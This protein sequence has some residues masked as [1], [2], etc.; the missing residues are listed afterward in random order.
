MGGC[1]FPVGFVSPANG[2][3]V[4][5]PVTEVRMHEMV[6]SAVKKPKKIRKKKIK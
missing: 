4:L 1:A 6:E 3:P 2:L 5:T